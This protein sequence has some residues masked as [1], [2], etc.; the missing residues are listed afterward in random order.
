VATLHCATRRPV[1]EIIFRIADALRGWV[2]DAP[3]HDDLT[4]IVAKMN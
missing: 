1:K 4:L 2:A 3:Q